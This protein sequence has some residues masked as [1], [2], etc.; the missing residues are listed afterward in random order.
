MNKR[1]I[2]AAIAAAVLLTLSTGAQAP[3]P[4][5]NQLEQM[6]KLNFLV[7][8]W[9]GEGWTEMVPG[10]RRT[11]PITE[12]VQS[13]LGGV[14]LLVEGLGKT[15]LAGQETETVTHNAL[16][17]L[18]YDEAAKKYRMRSFL[19]DGRYVDAEGEFTEGGFQ[20]AFSPSPALSIRYTVRLNERGE[21]FEIGEMSMNRGEW[22]R[23]H[24]M[25]L[26][27]IN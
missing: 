21:W 16:G 15:K 25:T 26:R 2:A 23:F 8:E 19:A 18:S 24:E 13:K 6:K 20:W 1:S 9:R 3:K 5:A 10:Q 17:V 12:V 11:S 14:V 22:R 7:G 4:S 27:K